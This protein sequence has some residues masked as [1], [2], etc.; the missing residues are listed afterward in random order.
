VA[1]MVP[2]PHCRRTSSVPRLSYHGNAKISL[3]MRGC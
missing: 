2:L 1:V 3:D